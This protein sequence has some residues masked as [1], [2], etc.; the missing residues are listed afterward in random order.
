MDNQSFNNM[1]KTKVRKIAFSELSIIQQKHTK[2][3]NIQYSGLS[4]PQEYPMRTTFPN[5]KHQ[6]LYNLP[7]RSVNGMKDNLY[8]IYDDE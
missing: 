6:L 1:V 5:K 2:V 8:P 4:A 3:R 7:C